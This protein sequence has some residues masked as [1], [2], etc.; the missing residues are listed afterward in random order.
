MNRAAARQEKFTPS[1]KSNNDH[2]DAASVFHQETFGFPDGSRPEFLYLRPVVGMNNL[3]SFHMHIE[4]IIIPNY[5]VWIFSINKVT[6]SLN[7]SVSLAVLR[8]SA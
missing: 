4:Y 3:I 7:Q 8:F 5:R 1:A 2:P 6:I